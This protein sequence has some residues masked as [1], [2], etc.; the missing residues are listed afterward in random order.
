[1]GLVLEILAAEKPSEGDLVGGLL[2][3][4]ALPHL[5]ILGIVEFREL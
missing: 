5:E 3:H 4:E 2:A 1:M